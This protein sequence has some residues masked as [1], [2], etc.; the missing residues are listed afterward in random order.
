MMDPAEFERL[1]HNG[2]G[3]AILYLRDHD[4]TPH[5]EAILYACLHDTVFDAQVNGSNAE[6]LY[7]VI[8]LTNEA[9]FYRDALLQGLRSPEEAYDFG[10]MCDLLR[11]FAQQGDQKARQALYDAFAQNEA[12]Y[13]ARF[14]IVDLDGL[15]GFLHIA[16]HSGAAAANDADFWE[17]EYF[18]NQLEE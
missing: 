13:E 14:A 5:R 10:H 2:R 9:D 4:A 15:P 16:E 18:L 8:S 12:I 17:G 1:L 6:Y 11:C 7:E 3:R